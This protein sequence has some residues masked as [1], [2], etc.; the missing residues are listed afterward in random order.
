LVKPFTVAVVVCAT[1]SFKTASLQSQPY[2]VTAQ[3]YGLNH[4]QQ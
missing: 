1:L 2:I 4:P 3:A